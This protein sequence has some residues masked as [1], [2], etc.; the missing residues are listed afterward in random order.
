MAS[1]LRHAGVYATD[2]TP[3]AGQRGYYRST[4]SGT[5]P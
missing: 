1:L 3:G 5:T 4:M 2:A